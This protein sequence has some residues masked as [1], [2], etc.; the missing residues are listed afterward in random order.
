MPH[1]TYAILGTGALGGYYGACLQRSGCHVHFLLKSDYDHVRRHGL[2]VD[3]VNGDFQLDRVHAYRDCSDMPKCSVVIVSLKTTQNH[4]L[5]DMLPHVVDKESV[6]LL[7]QNGLGEEDAVARIVGPDRVMSGLCFLCSNKIG[8]GH[9][10]HLDYGQ[11]KLGEYTADQSPGGITRRMEQIADDLKKAGIP[12]ALTE[13]LLLARWQKLVWN[14]PFNGLSVVLNRAT[15]EL[16]SHPHC[17]PLVEGLMQEVVRGAEA[18]CGRVIE[19]VF[20]RKMI[21]DTVRMKPYRTSMKIDYD[22][23]RPMETESIYGSPYRTALHAGCELPMTG[24]LYHQL[25]L[26]DHAH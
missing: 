14:I 13:D 19:Q 18:S 6:V 22:A 9:I 21:D 25:K 2:K 16:V 8:P 23:G 10:H 4:M 7:L 1:H 20:V 26:M 5:P 11:I 12:V 17:L 24:M 15:D 3:S